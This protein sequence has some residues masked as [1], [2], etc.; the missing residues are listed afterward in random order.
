MC[1]KSGALS[2]HEMVGSKSRCAGVSVT[3]PFFLSPT[4]LK[5][6]L[7]IIKFFKN[8][9]IGRKNACRKFFFFM[10]VHLEIRKT[11]QNHSMENT[12]P[13][14]QPEPKLSLR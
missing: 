11:A 4:P 3:H 6:V 5:K 2:A 8:V 10:R 9:I 12:F 14:P 1:V 13:T 7:L